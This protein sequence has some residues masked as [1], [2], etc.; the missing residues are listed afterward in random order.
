MV[1]FTFFECMRMLALH[2]KK[3]AQFVEWKDLLPFRIITLND[4]WEERT[5]YDRSVDITVC[6]MDADSSLGSYIVFNLMWDDS[7]KQM[8]YC[9]WED[10]DDIISFDATASTSKHRYRAPIPNCHFIMP[11]SQ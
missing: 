8:S 9:V 5:A 11:L 2:G 6:T 4:F 10:T 3:N 1:S 7:R